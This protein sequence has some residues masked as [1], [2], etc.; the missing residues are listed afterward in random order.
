MIFGLFQERIGFAVV[1]GMKLFLLLVLIGKVLVRLA[2]LLLVIFSNLDDDDLYI[3][4]HVDNEAGSY[5]DTITTIVHHN[6]HENS[7]MHKQDHGDLPYVID[8][9]LGDKDQ[10]CDARCSGV[11]PTVN[12]GGNN[13]Y[14]RIK[15]CCPNNKATACPYKGYNINCW[16]VSAVTDMDRVFYDTITFSP[17]GYIP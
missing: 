15:A 7:H 16:N 9:H 5:A 2:V 17:Q 8:R 12:E 4:H 6:F 11:R 10:T 13:L 14:N 3:E 1:L